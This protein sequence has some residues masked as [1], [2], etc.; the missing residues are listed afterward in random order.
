MLDIRRL[1]LLVELSRRGTI[2]SVGRALHLSPSGV[3]Q[4]LA[5]LETEAGVRLLEH[6]GRGVRLT[7]AAR[8]LVAHAEAVLARLERAE[9]DLASFGEDPRGRLRIA[10]FQTAALA[11]VP[12]L[13]DALDPI[14]QLRIELAQ[15]EPEQALPALLAHDFDLV[16]GEE[17]PG[18]P[19][20]ADPQVDR[21]DLGADPIR[22]ATPRPVG[23]TTALAAS[24][25]CAWVMEP[26][27][28]AS[29]AWATGQCRAAGF[30]PDVRYES[31]DLLTHLA[32]V[33]RGHAAAFLP[34]LVWRGRVPPVRL[35]ELP[36]QCRTI[37]TAVRRGTEHR[38]TVRAVREALHRV[39]A[40]NPSLIG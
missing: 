36:G 38:P 27:G 30:E 21:V 17:Y 12:D 24:S 1:N 5:L 9:S 37:F 40:G 14:G 29:R 25:E 33:E 7:D 4:Q 35:H 39:A 3:S 18:G 19:R 16:L 10:S 28:T 22:L 15:V 11:L 26:A 6:V 34:D 2:A 23:D 8:S 31:A 32:L 20:R 13:L